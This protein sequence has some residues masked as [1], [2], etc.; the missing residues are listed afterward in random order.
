MF[1]MGWRAARGFLF[2]LFQLLAAHILAY[3]LELGPRG[4]FWAMTLAF[5]LLAVVSAA[6][7]R[8]GKWK[9]QVV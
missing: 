3:T 4:V 1:R 8:R 6:V 2:W 5:S 9:K 7:F